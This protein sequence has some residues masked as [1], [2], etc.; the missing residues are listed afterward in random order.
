MIKE[1]KLRNFRG[2]DEH[3]IPLDQFT[4]LVG[5]N[6]AGKSTAV[7]ALR[8]IS[9]ITQR[10]QGLSYKPLPTWLERPK[11]E[12]GVTPATDEF[13][14][15]PK[16]LFHRLGDPPAEIIASFATGHKVEAIVGPN[17]EVVGVV[18]DEK[19]NVITDKAAALRTT[20]PRVS[21]LP[22]IGPLLRE[23][24]QLDP[25]YVRRNISSQR[26][27]LHFRN[28]LHIMRE[29]I[30]GFKKLAEE[31][32]PK[33]RVEELVRTGLSISEF[34]LDLLVREADFTAEAG[35]MGH[36]L[37]MWLQTMWFLTHAAGADVVV[38]DEPDVYMHADLQRRLVRLLRSRSHQSVIATHSVEIMSE[39]SPSQ[40]VVIDRA[41]R[42]SGSTDTAPAV[43]SLLQSIGSIH[44][45]H[46][47]RLTASRR[48][49]LVEGDDMDYLKPLQDTLFPT[50]PTPIDTLPNRSLG[51]WNGWERALGLAM[52]L[53]ETGDTIQLYCILDSDYH[54]EEAISKRYETAK[55]ARI[56]LHIW[57]RKELENYLL[58]PSAIQRVISKGIKKGKSPSIAQIQTELD[59]ITVELQDDVFD[60]YAD[61]FNKIDRS[62]GVKGANR[63]AKEYLTNRYDDLRKRLERAPGKEILHKLSGWAQKSFGAPISAISLARNIQASEMDDELKAVLSAIE[64][65]SA[66]KNSVDHHLEI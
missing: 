38:L 53:K 37:Q 18:W 33:L 13:D 20:L 55:S 45:I 15:N 54:N 42:R 34:K 52:L 2:F 31:T 24:R 7:E 56:N 16:S 10:Y 39:V 50:S 46:L 4:L 65:C 60:C 32:W 44:N 62:Q 58:V 26:A 14:F 64:R 19:G 3:T 61:E 29:H 8:L 1:L 9:I 36:G 21:I 47:A 30:A 6:N 57:R 23:E 27:S 66:F 35:W 11:R 40:I 51:G 63:K 12:R 48:I 25:E 41:K 59:K 28:Q 17:G 22:Q 5:K 43:Q 49:I